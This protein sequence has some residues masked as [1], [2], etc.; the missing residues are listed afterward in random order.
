ML[1]QAARLPLQML[2]RGWR[3]GE[4]LETRIIPER[5][6]HRIEPK[7]RGSERPVFSERTLARH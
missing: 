5:I 4:S 6:E 2:L 1:G 7:Q 3:G